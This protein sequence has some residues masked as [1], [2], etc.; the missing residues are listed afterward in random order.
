[1][2]LD[3]LIRALEAEDPARIL[4]RGFCNPHSYRGYYRELAFEPTPNVTVGEMLA[5]AVSARGET[6]EGWKGGDFTM[7]GGTDCWLSLEGYASGETL[8]RTL[9][10]YMLEDAV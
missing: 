9:L 3:E 2:T 4:R 10:S 5:D 8:G 7:D 6:F 1:M